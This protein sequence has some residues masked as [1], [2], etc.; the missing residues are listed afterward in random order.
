MARFFESS[1]RIEIASVQLPTLFTFCAWIRDPGTSGFQRIA[2]FGQDKGLSFNFISGDLRIENTYTN[3]TQ[4]IHH[5]DGTD[6]LSDWNHVAWRADRSDFDD[7]I[8]LLVNGISRSLTSEKTNTGTPITGDLQALIGNRFDGPFDRAM[9][10]DIA[11]VS[12]YDVVLTDEEIIDAMHRGWTPRGLIA[13]LLPLWGNSDPEPD[14]SGSAKNGSVTGATGI[15]QMPP[16]IPRT[17]WM[18]GYVTVGETEEPEPTD[19]TPIHYYNRR[20]A[21]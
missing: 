16:V 11:W 14:M 6:D 7:T 19:G 1:D 18:P 9:E 13:P 21:A 5:W 8:E 10:G 2:E 4:S 20:R 12:F 15:S 3:D 17:L